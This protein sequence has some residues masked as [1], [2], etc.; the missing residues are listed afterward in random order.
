MISV[1]AN[2]STC[3]TI[4]FSPN[5]LVF[6]AIELV[7]KHQIY[8]GDGSECKHKMTDRERTFVVKVR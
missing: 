5:T 4:S 3:R 2:C 7:A 8:K 6:E 1:S